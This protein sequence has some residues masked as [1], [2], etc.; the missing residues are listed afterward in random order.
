MTLFNVISLL[1][2]L[3]LFLYGMTMME[4]SLER[5]SDGRL[6]KT[7][8]KMTDNLFKAVLVGLLVTAII[9]SSS[10][11]TVIVV[12][13]VNARIL[14]LRRAIGIIMGANIG[15]T[16]T[17]HIIS[18]SDISS[19]SSTILQLFKPTTLAPVAAAAGFLIYLLSKRAAKREIGLILIG[20]G[21]LFIGMFQMEAAVRPLQDAPAFAE[22][23]TRFSNPLLGVLAGLAVTAILQSSSA[24]IGILQALT[25][26]GAI[27]VSSAIPIILGQD[28]GTCITAMLASIGASKNGR[29][30][31]IIHVVF[32]ALGSVLFLI[33][34]YTV[35]YAVG[36]PFW[37]DPISKSGIAMFNTFFKV[38]TTLIFLPMTGV[39]EKI[40]FLLVRP[41]PDD[42]DPDEET[43]MLDVRFLASPG[44]AIAQA[45]AAVVKMAYHALDNSYRAA[46]LLERFDKKKYDRAQEVENVIDRLQSRVDQFLIQLAPK[47]LTQSE[48][49][50]LSEVLQVVNEFERL[51]DHCEKICGVA[52]ELSERSLS[53]SD[54]ARTEIRALR[55]AVLEIAALAVQGYEGRDI[56]L[57]ATIE[58]LK[59]VIGM[60]VQTIKVR[61]GNRLQQGLCQIGHAFP[62]IELISNMERIAG[63]CSNVGVHVIS[64]S[65]AAPML[66]RHEF[67]RDMRDSRPT[68]YQHTFEMYDN[69]YFER[70]NA[71]CVCQ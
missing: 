33:V 37:G 42:F 51:G 41:K 64:Y 5:A 9:Q 63:L 57:A 68:E 10:A 54:E 7:L 48:H 27:T 32:N 11:T 1:G 29:R 36:I 62:Y 34:L 30:A 58:P 16:V 26:T 20:F 45:R 17:A 38:V 65:G 56:N 8:E 3:A 49:M 52:L 67:L 59:E 31:A 18:L 71:S 43:S 19:A 53:F 61:H 15:T 24:S 4:K 22:V 6:E 47:D 60:L 28:I 2:G 50:A 35:Q 55:D 39:L 70:I 66:D 21:I 12:G 44:Y 13:L 69:K 40:S 46:E 14:K 23:F 25:V